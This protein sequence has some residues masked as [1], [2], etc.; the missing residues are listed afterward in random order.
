MRCSSLAELR[1]PGVL[2]NQRASVA[3]LLKRHIRHLER[4]TAIRVWAPAAASFAL[5]SAAWATVPEV[6]DPGGLSGQAS[7]D[8]L[9]FAPD[10]TTA[11]YDISSGKNVFIVI[12]RQTKGVWS[13]PEIAPFSGQWKDHDPA[14]APDGSFVVFASNRP[15]TPGGTPVGNWGT[16]WRVDRNR[17]GWGEPA[18][19][20]DSINEGN[21]SYAPSIANDGSLYFTRPNVAGIM[22]IFRSQYHKGSY[23][24]PVEQLVGN[25]AAHEKD[26]GISPDESFVV[27]D[28]NDPA[29]GDADRLFIA[30]RE[31]AHWGKAVDLGDVVNAENNP[32]GSHISGDGRTLYFTSDRTIPVGYPRSRDQ[33]ETDLKRLMS[34]D[35]GESHIWQLSLVPW[36]DA[37]R[38]R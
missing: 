12:S 18:R 2:S 21:R 34:W 14:L 22:R 23:E 17:D 9:S 13:K 7:E 25:P 11:V 33:A 19:L 20:P 3:T 6:L 35:N 15:P 10:G 5:A 8:C 32:W 4:L 31:G 28:S 16:L 1:D 26:P 37:H 24:P 36:I 27:F 29:K 38:A 30:F